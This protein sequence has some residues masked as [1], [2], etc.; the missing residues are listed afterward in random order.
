MAGEGAVHGWGCT[1]PGENPQPAAEHPGPACLP[2]VVFRGWRKTALYCILVFLMVL[3]F[4]NI[5]LTLW[6]ISSLKLR[7][8]GLGPITIIKGGIELEGQAFVTDSL[9]ASTI[10]SRSG[11]P[12]TVHSYR[13]FTCYSPGCALYHNHARA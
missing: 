7:M 6:I 13:N 2:A 8:G 4:L 5:G 9:V 10:R 1:P 12:L 3:I 11:Q